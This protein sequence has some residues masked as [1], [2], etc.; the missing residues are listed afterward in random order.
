MTPMIR[1]SGVD[2]KIAARYSS[3]AKKMRKGLTS[4]NWSFSGTLIYETIIHNINTVP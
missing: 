4:H 3:P 1:A 2:K